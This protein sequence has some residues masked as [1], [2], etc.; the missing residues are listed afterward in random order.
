MTSR[1]RPM[2]SS[3]V[4]IKIVNNDFC[5]FLVSFTRALLVTKRR[6]DFN[7]YLWI[8]LASLSTVWGNQ[9]VQ[10][11]SKSSW[12]IF[13]PLQ[14]IFL[15]IAS[16]PN[17]IVFMW[18]Y[19]TI[20]YRFYV[21]FNHLTNYHYHPFMYVG[22]DEAARFTGFFINRLAPKEKEPKLI[23]KVNFKI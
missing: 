7:W 20:L 23:L 5:L 14:D 4:S 21:E 15:L 22:S 18:V 3:Y 11:F 17:I 1:V 6:C 2:M 12:P 10:L 9:L 13:V 8:L 16:H 19:F